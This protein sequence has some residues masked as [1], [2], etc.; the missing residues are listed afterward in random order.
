ML[1]SYCPYTIR[2][3]YTHMNKGHWQ[4]PRTTTPSLTFLPNTGLFLPRNSGNLISSPSSLHLTI[5]CYPEP[6]QTSGW[7]W[8]FLLKNYGVYWEKL[9]AHPFILV[10]KGLKLTSF[11]PLFLVDL[12]ASL[13]QE[14]LSEW[15]CGMTLIQIGG[16]LIY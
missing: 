10:I 8:P 14:S 2:D 13:Y 7:D 4:E 6:N 12:D 16:R 3:T 11:F 1:F 9:K 5:L 15:F